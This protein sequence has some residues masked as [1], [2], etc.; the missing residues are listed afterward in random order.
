[1]RKG[2]A[3]VISDGK[4]G[5]LQSCLVTTVK[6]MLEIHVLTL[7]GLIFLCKMLQFSL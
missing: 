5:I 4:K 3:D 7:R 6:L 2:K 1:M